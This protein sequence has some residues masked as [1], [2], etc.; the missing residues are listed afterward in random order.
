MKAGLIKMIDIKHVERN[1]PTAVALLKAL[2]NESRLMIL[3]VLNKEGE[4]SVGGLEE[5][6]GLSQSALSQHLAR[7]RK[8]GLVK[9]RRNA[10]TIYYS[11]DN[12]HVREV[13]DCLGKLYDSEVR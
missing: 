12:S 10:Q 8:D 1:V 3:C 13:L 6:V 11:C 7:M 4:K 2:A 5:I 9:T